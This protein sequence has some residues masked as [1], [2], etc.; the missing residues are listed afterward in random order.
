MARL[1]V[2]EITRDLPEE[3]GWAGEV[4]LTK[5][6]AERMGMPPTYFV[7]SRA[8]NED[9]GVF[10]VR[11]FPS[12]EEG[13][14]DGAL[15]IAALAGDGLASVLEGDEATLEAGVAAQVAHVEGTLASYYGEEVAV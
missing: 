3:C 8:F 12:N 9:T 4:V 2:T 14:I 15:F 7:T 6:Q 5:V 13:F 1:T 11:S 10:E